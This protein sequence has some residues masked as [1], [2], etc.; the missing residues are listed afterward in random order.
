MLDVHESQFEALVMLTTRVFV[1]TDR[2]G[3]DDPEDWSEFYKL[4]DEFE[5]MAGRQE[6]F[7]DD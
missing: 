1:V 7:D 5:A 6:A 3:R 2:L 4:R